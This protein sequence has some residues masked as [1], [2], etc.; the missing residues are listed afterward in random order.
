MGFAPFGKV[1]EG[2]DVVKA[3][4][5][6]YREQPNQG[7]VQ[8]KGNAYLKSEFPNLDYIKSVSLVTGDAEAAPKETPAE[9]PAP[10]E[11]TQ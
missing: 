6:Q 1:V 4:N 8:S 2:F 5:A 10:V 11:A 9:E 7:L 3:I